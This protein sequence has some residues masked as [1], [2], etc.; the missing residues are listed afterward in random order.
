MTGYLVESDLWARQPE[1][2]S[3]LSVAYRTTMTRKAEKSGVYFVDPPRGSERPGSPDL[4]LWQT[5]S[6]VGMVSPEKKHRGFSEHIY[7]F[8]YN[9]DFLTLHKV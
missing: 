9:K 1:L 2:A 3:I 4:V 7:G 8:V 5:S 6:R